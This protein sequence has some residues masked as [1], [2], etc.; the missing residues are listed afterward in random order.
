VTDITL[1][2]DGGNRWRA[3]VPERRFERIR[4]LLGRH[5]LEPNEAL[6]LPR[7]R[8]IH[9]VGMRFAIRVAF[10]DPDLTVLAVRDVP[11]GRPLV[12][13]R[14]ARH[15]LELP[16]AADILAGDRLR[17]SLPADR[18]PGPDGADILSRLHPR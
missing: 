1:T 8:S 15:I 11:P 2:T 17:P 13:H 9:T 14:R 16:A 4:G 6:L 7:C 5:A 3:R 18:E 10:L 12:G